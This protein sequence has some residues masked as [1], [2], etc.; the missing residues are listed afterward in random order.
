MAFEDQPLPSTTWTNEF[1]KR[2]CSLIP[3]DHGRTI[4]V[5]CELTKL[6]WNSAHYILKKIKWTCTDA[7]KFLPRPS[8]ENDH[9]KIKI[10]SK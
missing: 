7:T 1:I 4:G 10:D 2:I 8:S 5:F 3:A 6:S 9:R